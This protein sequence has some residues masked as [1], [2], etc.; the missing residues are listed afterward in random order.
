VEAVAAL[1]VAVGGLEVLLALALL[2]R[3]VT[4]EYMAVALAGRGFLIILRVAFL[5]LVLVAL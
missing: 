3:A 1:A 4:G 2:V 5:L